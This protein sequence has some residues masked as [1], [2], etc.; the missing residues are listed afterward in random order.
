MRSILIIITILLLVGVSFSQSSK[1][2]D[3]WRGLRVFVM[4]KDS[5]DQI[6]GKPLSIRDTYWT[7]YYTSEARVEINFTSKPCSS[8]Q[9]EKGDFDVPENTILE[10]AVLPKQPFPI[11]DLIWSREKY[12]IL[13]GREPYIKNYYD[14]KSGIGVTTSE[15]HGTE[16]VGQIFF[17]A[18]VREKAK[19]R[20]NNKLR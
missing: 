2:E 6:L 16:M 4:N 17:R 10:F 12:E 5:V 1:I 7:T 3:G 18:P 8:A 20:C 15:E 9:G 11:K 13:P 19:R 14:S